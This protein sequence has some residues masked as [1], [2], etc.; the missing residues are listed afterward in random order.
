MNRIID[1]LRNEQLTLFV[2]AGFSRNA[3]APSC[4]DI[5][6]TIIRTFP[7]DEQADLQGKQLDEL[8]NIYVD[9]RNGNKEDLIRLIEPLFNFERK[10][11]MDH[12]NLSNIP[13]IHK[14]ITTNYDTL[15]EDTYGDRCQV[16][17][18]NNDV[19][20]IDQTKDVHIF[21]IHGD[22]NHPN[23]ILITK[24]D[25]FDF[26]RNPSNPLL[27][28][29]VRSELAQNA[30]AF[31]GY[32]LSDDNIQY[33]LHRI[34]EQTTSE[35]KRIFLIS[36]ALT[37]PQRLKLKRMN[38]E[39]IQACGDTFLKEAIEA[40]K[41]N[42]HKDI[43]KGRISTKTMHQFCNR[44]GIDIELS[45]TFNGNEIVKARS[46]TGEKYKYNLALKK[47]IPDLLQNIGGYANTSLT[48]TNNIVV[49]AV[50]IRRDDIKSYSCTINGITL[51]DEEEFKTFLIAPEMKE[52]ILC[53]NVP[54]ARFNEKVTA[55]RYSLNSDTVVTKFHTPI[56]LIEITTSFNQETKMFT[57]GIEI[58][59]PNA[60]DNLRNAIYWMKAII[61][62]WS[63]QKFKIVGAFGLD[64]YV[65]FP[66]P[67]LH[68]SNF[69]EVLE[70]LQNLQDIEWAAGITFCEYSS[71]S[72]DRL[73]KSRI[74]RGFLNNEPV[75]HKIKHDSEITVKLKYS[76]HKTL[77]EFVLSV[78]TSFAVLQR[79]DKPFELCGHAFNIP[80][81]YSVFPQYR[82]KNRIE[83]SKEEY[84]VT[85]SLLEDAYYSFYSE[86][87]RL[88]IIPN[89]ELINIDDCE[90][91]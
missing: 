10:Y 68:L 28:D 13:H 50:E 45:S 41:K 35:R 39:Y 66:D 43:R 24:S 15:L 60:F 59:T 81:E 17:A 31:I 57:T 90:E 33:I 44:H 54:S 51:M 83:L 65:V 26:Y 88:D 29:V 48:F 38:V 40:L 86:D 53:L 75:T 34:S 80:V 25:Y 12:I 9:E 8:S 14:I 87:E 22:F 63:G 36:P 91:N 21:K 18:S 72:Y 7:E 11:S 42:I 89:M 23:D 55:Y 16:I 82:Y 74:I 64:N 19:V 56:G 46:L 52:T 4:W 70:Y 62:M 69:P 27:W 30:I 47:I 37:K 2:G 6:Q 77:P 1:I 73:F 58:R 76:K 67:Q 3:G 32:S 5:C 79:H 20:N 78:D 84:G 85:L 49:P 71:F 61:D